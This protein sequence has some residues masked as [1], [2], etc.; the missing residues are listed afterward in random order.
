M[1]DLGNGLSSGLGGVVG[2][3]AAFAGARP[4]ITP[5]IDGIWCAVKADVGCSNRRVTATRR[6]RDVT[7]GLATELLEELRPE[8]APGDPEDESMDS[9]VFDSAAV[10]VRASE[11][12]KVDE[13]DERADVALDVVEELEV[14]EMLEVFEKA[15]EV[16]DSKV[17]ASSER[18]ERIDDV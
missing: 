1:A 9:S 11:E 2:V 12:V 7:D 18:L 5:G 15:D 6:T 14:T 10:A 4:R 13:A 8:D 3:K 17:V 16:R